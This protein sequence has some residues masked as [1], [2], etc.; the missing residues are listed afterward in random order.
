MLDERIESVLAGR[1][2]LFLGVCS[3]E[4]MCVG[5]ERIKRE[6]LLRPNC[7]LIV[8][9]N[10]HYA[11][12]I[13]RETH[14]LYLDSL[15]SKRLPQQVRKLLTGFKLPVFHNK[16]ILQDRKSVNCALYCILFV[17]L[18]DGATRRGLS[19]K[20][21]KDRLADN[22]LMACQYIKQLLFQ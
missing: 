16:R 10:N 18:F 1:T 17:L 15:S 2:R 20:W 21:S 19:L 12:V 14:I 6:A 9:F 22:D 8:H 3:S 5:D 4:R 13:K 11:C 7:S